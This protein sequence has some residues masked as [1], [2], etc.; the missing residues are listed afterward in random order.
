MSS[1]APPEPAVVFFV[2]RSVG[3]VIVPTALRAAGATVI[4]HD[5]RF[6][7]NTPDSVW[8]AQ[9][10]ANAWVVITRDSRLR[11]KPNEKEALIGSG[12]LV[13]VLTADG[14]TGQQHAELAV[15]ALPRMLKIARSH[16]RP[17]I[18]SINSSGVPRQIDLG[19]KNRRPARDRR[20]R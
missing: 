19:H 7:E 17:A 20:R 10:G 15:R 6:P 14:L 11:Y 4:T 2:D 13:F 8:L 9:A 16:G 1:G 18:F 5:E 3:G 12:A